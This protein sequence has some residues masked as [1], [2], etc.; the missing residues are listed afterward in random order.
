MPSE[1]KETN[2]LKA[3]ASKISEEPREVKLSRSDEM[4]AF[5]MHKV[6]PAESVDLLPCIV[7]VSAS[8]GEAVS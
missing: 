2:I 8:S 4:C 7:F 6:C 1:E 3:L 5:L